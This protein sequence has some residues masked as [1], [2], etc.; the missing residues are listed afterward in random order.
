MGTAFD[1]LSFTD[2]MNPVAFLDCTKTMSNRDRRSSLSGT[3]E[4]VLYNTFAIA[5]QCRSSFVQ[6]QDGRVSQ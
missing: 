5:V 2:K 6:Q 1:D 4:S 3:V